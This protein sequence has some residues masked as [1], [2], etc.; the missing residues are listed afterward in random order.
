M[1]VYEGDQTKVKIQVGAT[2]EQHQTTV[3]G[4]KWLSNG[5]GFGRSPNSGWRNFQSHGISEQFSLQTPLNP[6][7]QQAGQTVD[8]LYAT[9]AT[10]DGRITSYNVCYTKLLRYRSLCSLP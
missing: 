5:S 3:H 7:V 8:Y 10:R 2:E 6:A 9:D 1:R 4:I